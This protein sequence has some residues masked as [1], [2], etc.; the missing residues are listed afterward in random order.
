MHQEDGDIVQFQLDDEPLDAGVEVMKPLTPHAWRGEKCIRL[1]TH[2]GHQLINRRHAV[3]AL[4]CR[5]MAQRACDEIGLID[6]AGANRTGIDFDEA[7]Q[8]P[9]PAA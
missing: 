7:D 6:H 2:D 1:L 8:R 9:D 5:V 3:L 4:E